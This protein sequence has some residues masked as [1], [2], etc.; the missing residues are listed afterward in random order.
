MTGRHRTCCPLRKGGG[1]AGKGVC[2]YVLKIEGNRA[3]MYLNMKYYSNFM[4]KTAC[5]LILLVGMLKVR[6][7]SMLM[8][9]MTGFD[10]SRF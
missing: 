2:D 5:N 9:E 10:L 8:V 3:M 7:A 4:I 6:L 1:R